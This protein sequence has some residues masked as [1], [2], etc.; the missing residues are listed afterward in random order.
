MGVSWNRQIKY[1]FLTSSELFFYKL[2]SVPRTP[3]A[4]VD[5]CFGFYAPKN[6]LRMRPYVRI[7]KVCQY[8]KQF[9]F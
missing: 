8:I 4:L 2:K 1:P 6:K 3:R 9:F 5:Y 7:R